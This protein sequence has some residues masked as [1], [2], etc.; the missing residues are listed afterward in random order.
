MD[1]SQF[2]SDLLATIIGAGLALYGAI[3][4]DRK[5]R[6]RVEAAREKEKQ[7]KREQVL[8][9][10]RD[11]LSA[12]LSAL[13]NIDDNVPSTYR[14]IRVETWQAFS[15]GGSLEPIDD[16]KLLGHISN[17][18]ANSRHFILLYYRFFDMAFFPAKNA[19]DSLKDVF[20]NH[21]MK[22]KEDAKSSIEA[23]IQEIMLKLPSK[24]NKAAA[25][26]I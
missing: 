1:F 13:T 9:L 22:A 26:V 5:S 3:W 15:D 8:S 2:V 23:T 16:P 25:Q 7:E 14:H 21:T 11:E 10:I 12:N 19:Y 24:D 4:L 17:A 6:Y 18:C 20:L